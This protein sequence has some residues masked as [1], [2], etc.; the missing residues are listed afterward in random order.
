MLL[1][2]LGN[3]S[4]KC[5]LWKDDSVTSLESFYLDENLAEKL[6]AWCRNYAGQEVYISSVVPEKLSVVK[7]V[8]EQEKF[9][10]VSI[11]NTAEFEVID[12]DVERKENVGIDR[13]LAS[14]AAYK[15]AGKAVITVDLG[16]AVT[17]DYVDS[18]GV[19]Q[20]GAIMPGALLWHKALEQNTS[21]LPLISAEEKPQ[22]SVGKN[23]I[24]AIQAGTFFGIAGAVNSLVEKCLS[25]AGGDTEI[26]VTGGGYETVKEN[27]S[28]KHIFDK[29]LVFKG[30]ASVSG[31]KK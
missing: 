22:S 12:A 17:V 13:L 4:L 2:D 6:G 27:L 30:I 29:N 23:T 25:E 26:Y 16:S 31:R 24:S 1:F 19:F 9:T 8:L 20:G 15:E 21:Q 28:F 3:T 10:Q 11:I 5:A 7:E 14:A 18:C